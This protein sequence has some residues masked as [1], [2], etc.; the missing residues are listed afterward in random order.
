MPLDAGRTT[1]LTK[2]A[3]C[4]PQTP[5]PSVTANEDRRMMVDR[6]SKQGEGRPGMGV[7]LRFRL[8]G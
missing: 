2:G 7:V 4:G 1:P 6:T 3:G 5:K 8:H